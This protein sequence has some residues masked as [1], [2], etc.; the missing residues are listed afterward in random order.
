MALNRLRS[1][2]RVQRGPDDP[3]GWRRR[4]TGRA[5]LAETCFTTPAW[6]ESRLAFLT[7]KLRAPFIFAYWCGD[8]AVDRV[9]QT[10]AARGAR[11]ASSPICT[12]T[13]TRPRR[14]TAHWPE[15]YR[16]GGRAGASLTGANTIDKRQHI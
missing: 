9:W 16:A 4:W 8:V 11:P 3:P 13:C 2:A 6:V 10:G 5:Y 15:F 14:W 1:A 12:T 7:H